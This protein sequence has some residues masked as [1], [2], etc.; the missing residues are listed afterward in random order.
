MM[1]MIDNPNLL[2]PVVMYFYSTEAEALKSADGAE[3][4]YCVK[5]HTYYVPM[6]PMV[7]EVEAVK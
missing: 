4:W 1:H 7:Q 5:N 2:P 3:F 6:V